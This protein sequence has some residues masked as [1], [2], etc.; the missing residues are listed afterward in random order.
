[1]MEVPSELRLGGTPLLQTA[2]V[3]VEMTKRFVKTYSV[4]KLNVCYLTDGLGGPLTNYVSEHDNEGY[5]K[6]K[7]IP[8]RDNHPSYDYEVPEEE[9]KG[10][11]YGSN[12]HVK[13]GKHNHFDIPPV[14]MRTLGN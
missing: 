12:T 6:V 2:L 13:V 14:E 3:N 5:V 8:T 9:R 4:D 7:T 10:R 1:M 11:Y